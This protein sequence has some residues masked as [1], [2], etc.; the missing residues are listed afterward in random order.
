VV[1]VEEMA[2]E[3]VTM[4]V[5]VPGASQPQTLG[6][7]RLVVSEG[8]LD[9]LSDKGNL[10]MR[11]VRSLEMPRGE[12]IGGTAGVVKVEFGED[13]DLRAVTL[14]NMSKGVLKSRSAT[15]EMGEALRQKLQMKGL[16]QAE[17]ADKDRSDVAV[18]RAVMQK[19]KT[20]MW[21]WGLIAVAGAIATV[22]SMS[23]A[24]DGGGTYYFFWG[25]IV[26]GLFGVL[27][28]YFDRY[29][30]NKKVVDK[31]GRTGA[32]AGAAA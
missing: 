9:F 17:A 19:A 31:A 13:R 25:A 1:D 26:F 15:K 7:G 23:A 16:T 22:V 6:K 32:G 14:V 29:R 10:S 27:E 3:K 8:G 2:F 11:P 24:S 5:E 20:Q 30:K 21:V 28:A 18:A 12:G 4:F